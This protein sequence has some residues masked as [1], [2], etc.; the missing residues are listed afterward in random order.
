MTLAQLE[1]R[2]SSLEKTVEE[3]QARLPPG[4]DRAPATNAEN[5]VPS[6]DE[7]ILGTECP[8]V[9]TKPPAKEILLRGTIVSI[10]RGPQEL[11][12]SDAEWASLGLEEDDG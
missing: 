1:Q 8:L 11:G 5:A 12:L 2:I 3:L 7:I 6:E 4:S 10:E 9:L